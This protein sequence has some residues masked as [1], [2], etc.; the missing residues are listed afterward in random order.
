M[1]ARESFVP[2]VAAM[3]AAERDS[4]RAPDGTQH[5]R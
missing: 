3:I 5:R 4:G 2:A 1:T